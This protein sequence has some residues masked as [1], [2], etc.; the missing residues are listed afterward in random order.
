MN[1]IQK[2]EKKKNCFF[3]F[4]GF[5]LA[6]FVCLIASGAVSPLQAK[7]ATVSPKSVS[8][9][10]GVYSVSVKQK[11][12]DYRTVNV[13]LQNVKKLKKAG[14]KSIKANVKMYDGKT[15][16]VNKSKTVKLSQVDKKTNT[17]TFAAPTF[18]KYTAKITF[19][20]KK[21]K[22]LK[23]Q[24]MKN[25]GI[26]AQ[27]YN[28]AVLNG[29]FGP[30][31]Y[32]LSLWDNDVVRGEKGNP[33]PSMIALSRSDSYNWE[34]LPRNVY[35]CPLA[36]SPKSG[37]FAKKAKLMS[38]YVG[39]LKKLNKNSKFHFYFADNY[40]K[41]IFDVITPNKIK[42]SNYDVTFITD[43]SGS[44]Y[45]FNNVYDGTNAQSV[46]NGMIKEWNKTM[47]QAEKGK[48]ITGKNLKYA[49][50]GNNQVMSKYCYAAVCASSNIRWWVSR[51]TGTFESKDSV[52]LEQAISKM[53]VKNM[54]DML[55]ILQDTGKAD[56]F[57][58]LYHFSDNMFAAAK[59]NHKE[60]MIL[61]GSRVTSEQNFA[62]FSKF[63]KKNYGSKYEYYYK[64]HPAT[65]TKLYP[66]KA[67]ELKNL[68]IHDIDASIP[69]E[70][71][72][73]FNKDVYVAGMS[74]STLNQ[75]YKAGHTKVYFGARKAASGEI[76]AGDLFEMFFTKID[77]S[78]EEAVRSLCNLSDENFL[79]EYKDTS[80]A[81]IA[82]YDATKN[83]ITKY[84]MQKDGSYK[85][86]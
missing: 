32:S 69:A 81:D 59:K 10:G 28:I 62:E 61:M 37:T 20:N 44:Y 23:T 53:Q 45:W 47:Q 26:V 6:L 66:K 8:A 50:N 29:T 5:F 58:Q 65:P 9:K 42:T 40:V 70:L 1:H 85:K 33:I 21:G 82:I 83:Q 79:V 64:G 60:V 27:E 30:L 54:N 84:K 25:L 4:A 36:K 63:V 67:K 56:A 14:V 2:N 13:K 80:K 86:I 18:G 76:M 12:V 43:G 24:T 15:V 46:H 72:L 49:I 19:Y 11:A 17:F 73:F 34:K 41:G 7:A 39:E 74:N 31:Y 78:Y 16:M 57:K 71:I 48:T 68:G 77:D 3:S 35:A 38:A 52:F 51:T 75:A 55:T 22:V